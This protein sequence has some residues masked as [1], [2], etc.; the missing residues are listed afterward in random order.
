MKLTLEQIKSATQGAARV[1]EE[2]DGVHLYRFTQHQEEIY[3]AVSD[4]FYKKALATSG[5]VLEFVTDSLSLT[6]EAVTKSASSREFVFH[7]IYSNGNLVAHIGSRDTASGVFGGSCLLGEG[8]KT[9]QIYLPWS[10][11]STL[12]LLELD[13]GSLFTPIQRPNKMLI[14]GD[15]ITQ[16][17]DALY[18]SHSYASVLASHLNANARNKGIGGEQFFSPLLEEPDDMTPDY[19]TVA[20]GT[21]DWSHKTEQELDTSM[22]E[23]YRRLSEL[24]PQSRIFAITP[25]W[26]RDAFHVK[27]SGTFSHM[28]ELFEKNTA[29]LQ[30]VT[31]IHGY[32]L[33]PHDPTLFADG[34]V[35]PNDAGFAYYAERLSAKI[36]ALLSN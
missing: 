21:N 11:A 16:G 13:D 36:K 3:R 12:R 26:R 20:Y 17:Y 6:L 27:P 7:D 32:D 33:V 2:T 25:I 10:A 15:S 34:K 9:V 18:P 19:I 1:T 24:Y 29:E 5:I 14:F 4:D 8:I 30:N 35:H 31:I 28:T 23:F 22:H